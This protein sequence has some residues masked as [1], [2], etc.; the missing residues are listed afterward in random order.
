MVAESRSRH[1]SSV[2]TEGCQIGHANIGDVFFGRDDS[3]CIEEVLREDDF[4][5]LRRSLCTTSHTGQEKKRKKKKKSRLSSRG[6]F[7]IMRALFCIDFLSSFFRTSSYS[8][9]RTKDD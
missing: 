6:C 8:K 7:G 4:L 3:E 9:M 5:A 2:V 1:G